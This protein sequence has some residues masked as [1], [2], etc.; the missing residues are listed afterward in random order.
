MRLARAKNLRLVGQITATITSVGL[1]AVVAAGVNT[2]ATM[3]A[4]GINLI[5][6]LC[7]LVAAHLET[8]LHGGKGN[9]VDFFEKLVK[10]EAEAKQLL[11]EFEI[12]QGNSANTNDAM[13]LV[14]RANAL[15]ADL[16]STERLLWRK[17]QLGSEPN[18]S[19]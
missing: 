3:V 13:E 11:M 7:A 10:Q 16:S 5:A 4:A 6:T 14:R 8:P 1:V 18:S 2:I 9:L 17:Q 15:A 12:C 19:K